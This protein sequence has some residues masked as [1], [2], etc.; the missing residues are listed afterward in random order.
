M[1]D[2][3]TNV[4]VLMPIEKCKELKDTAHRL[5]VSRSDL[6]REGTDIVL[7]KYDEKDSRKE[8]RKSVIR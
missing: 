8:S 1:K 6:V 2:Y 5:G 3:L 4:H 7:K